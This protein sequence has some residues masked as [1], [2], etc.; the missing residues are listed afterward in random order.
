MS[1]PRQG[2][3]APPGLRL[4]FWV[5]LILE[6]GFTLFLIWEGRIYA[7]LTQSLAFNQGLFSMYDLALQF[8][9]LVAYPAALFLVFYR[10]GST[11]TIDIR[12]QYLLFLGLAFAGSA[13][14]GLIGYALESLIYSGGFGFFTDPY[15][16]EMLSIGIVRSSAGFAFLAFTGVAVGGFRS[17]KDSAPKSDQVV[18]NDSPQPHVDTALGLLTTKPPPMSFS[19]L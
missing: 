9:Q 16:L 18:L 19:D 4:I 6:I 2:E 3:G 7:S 15:S 11:K 13:V 14:G 1:L 5:S 17:L 10:I 8:S 12:S